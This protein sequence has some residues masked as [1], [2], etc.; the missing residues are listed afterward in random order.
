MGRDLTAAVQAAADAGHVRVVVF[1]D[2][3]FASTVLRFVAAPYNI[4]YNG[5]VYTGTGHLGRVSQ[6]E[7]GSEQRAYQLKFEISGLDPSVVSVA[8][9]EDYQG[10]PCNLYLGVYDDN[11]QI[12]A[13]PVLLFA[14]LM[15]TMDTEA[16]A[17]AKITIVANSRLI[18]WE[19]SSG[20]RFNNAMQQQRYPDDKGLEFMEQMVEKEIV[21]PDR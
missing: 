21:W 10:R 4:T 15:D 9:S 13:D 20:M 6:V 2:F 18:R 11:Y 3:D 14:G 17:T 16:G 1:A 8:L 7:E 5:N 12:I 19:E